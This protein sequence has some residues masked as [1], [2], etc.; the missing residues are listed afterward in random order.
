VTDTDKLILQRLDSMGNDVKLVRELLT[1][2][3]EPSKGL[4]VR[5]DRLEQSESR[6]NWLATTAIGAAIT[7]LAGVAVKY[8]GIDR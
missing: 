2:N 7:A 6:R 4:I 3:G 1:G 8:L 5:V